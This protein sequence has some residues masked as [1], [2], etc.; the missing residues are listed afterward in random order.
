MSRIYMKVSN[1]VYLELLTRYLKPQWRLA[2]ALGFLLVAFTT[3][4]FVSP[5]LLGSFIDNATGSAP[6]QTLIW[7]ALGFLG[8]AFLT[9]LVSVIEVYVA[10]NLG[11]LATNRLRSDVASHCLNLDIGYLNRYTPGEL[12]ERIDG[13]VAALGNFFSRFVVYLL[14]NLLLLLSVLGLLVYFDWRLGLVLSLVTAAGALVIIRIRNLATPRWEASRQAKADMFGFIEERLNGTEDIKSAGAISYTMSHLHRH[15]GR[16]LRNDLKAGLLTAV[17]TNNT[18]FFLAI[19]TAAALGMIIFLFQGGEISLGTAF[20]IYRYTEMLSRP[21]E[22]INRQMQDFQ[23]ATASIAR[24]KNLLNTPISIKTNAESEIRLT[25]Q[26]LTVDFDRVSFEYA[27]DEPVLEDISFQLPQGQVLGLLGRSGSGKTTLSRLLFRLYDPTCGVIRL[28]QVAITDLPLAELRR[29]IGLVTQ[30]IQLFHASVRDNLTF[31]DAEI[32]DEQII[33]VITELGL[34]S[35]F[36]RL[37]HG[38][39][40]RLAPTGNSLSGGEA[41]LLSFAR[42]FLKNPQLVIL[43]EATSRLDPLTENRV[44]LAV[45]RLLKG[46]T[47]IIIAHRLATVQRVDRIMILENGR[48]LETGD[49]KSLASDANSRFNRL[50]KAGLEDTLA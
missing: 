49:R 37:E 48:I 30:E 28:N 12:I 46:R 11:W 27:E 14:G 7:L 31:F 1:R 20:L 19:G 22:E 42:V 34:A 35:W 8:L 24:V 3:L 6:E 16:S 10:E 50:L 13:D 17:I 25:T 2:L 33:N 4:Q 9:Q 44:E 23:Q 26:P 32:S 47:A 45:N 21:V 36:N 38:L 43:D 15:Q 5:L 18:R 39:E 40:T 29:H 41:Q